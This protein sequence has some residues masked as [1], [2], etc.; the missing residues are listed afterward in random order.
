VEFVLI[1]CG[2]EGLDNVSWLDRLEGGT[3]TPAA[4]ETVVVVS[5]G[6]VAVGATGNLILGDKFGVAIVGC[7][8]RCCR[9]DNSAMTSMSLHAARFSSGALPRVRRQDN[10]G[11]FKGLASGWTFAGWLAGL[12]RTM[13]DDLID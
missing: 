8:G 10:G 1:R 3:F 5:W 7:A 12:L 13:V 6:K 9:A 4:A 2:D 11:G